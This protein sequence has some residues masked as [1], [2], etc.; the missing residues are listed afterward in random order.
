MSVL[1][2]PLAAARFQSD[3]VSVSCEVSVWTRCGEECELRYAVF[4]GPVRILC[5]A[6]GT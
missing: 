4:R 3:D 2:D 5:F 1:R 6:D